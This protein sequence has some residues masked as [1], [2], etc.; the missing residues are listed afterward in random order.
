M[1]I[2]IPVD[3]DLDLVRAQIAAAAE[4]GKQELPIVIARDVYVD[5]VTSDL[6]VVRIELP[7]GAPDFAARL[8]PCACRALGIALTAAADIADQ[9]LYDR[10]RVAPLER[11][12][13]SLVTRLGKG[14]AR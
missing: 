4:R 12:G 3:I 2:S 9:D 5:D 8:A 13:E 6:P 1:S 11:D 14:S 7:G 10:E